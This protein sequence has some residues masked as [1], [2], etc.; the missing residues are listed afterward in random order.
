MLDPT[1]LQQ[2]ARQLYDAR[3]ARTPLR[4]FSRQYPG[5]TVADGYAIQREWV[6][7]ELADGRRVRGRKIGL[8]SRA[9][10]GQ[11]DRRARLRAADGRHVLR[12]GR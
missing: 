6:K 11:P 10:P 12:P 2:L 3:K 5:M 7:L 9:M 4:Q 8:T 1:T